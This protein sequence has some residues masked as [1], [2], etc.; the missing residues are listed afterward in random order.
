MPKARGPYTPVGR[1]NKTE[2]AYA[3]LLEDQRRT[4]VIKWWAYE[5]C[6]LRLADKT[7]YTPDFMVVDGNDEIEFHEV[8]GFWRDD[9]RAKIK[10]ANELFPFRFLA[11]TKSKTGWDYEEF[12]RHV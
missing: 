1:M 3:G 9:A 5:P 7:T 6:K 11:V 10:I 2:A 8:K 12:P 4:G